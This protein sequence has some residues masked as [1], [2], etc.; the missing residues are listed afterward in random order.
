MPFLLINLKTAALCSLLVDLLSSYFE[1]LCLVCAFLFQF[2]LIDLFFKMSE[3][4]L[5]SLFLPYSGNYF[6]YA[7]ICLWHSLFRTT[8]LVTKL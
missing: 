3:A 8:K 1:V 4:Y 6:K 2:L 7:A 5:H